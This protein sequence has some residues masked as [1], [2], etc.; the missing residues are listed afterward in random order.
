MASLP[1]KTEIPRARSAEPLWAGVY[2]VAVGDPV[3]IRD[4]TGDWHDAIADSR[5]ER[6]Y[7]FPILWVNSIG[8]NGEPC[9]LPWPIDA[10]APDARSA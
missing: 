2:D 5:V 4:A 9:R 8:R 1:Q 3:R 6:G 10:V 7:N